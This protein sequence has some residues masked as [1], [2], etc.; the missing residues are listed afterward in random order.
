MISI[1]LDQDE[2]ETSGIENQSGGREDMEEVEQ[3][4]KEERR[5]SNLDLKCGKFS[6]VLCSY[7]RRRRLCTKSKGFGKRGLFFSRK[8]KIPSFVCC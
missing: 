1:H 7:F 2:G 3:E 5:I 4:G 8:I 6:R